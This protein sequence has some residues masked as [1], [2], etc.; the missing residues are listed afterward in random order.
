M[1]VPVLRGSLRPSVVHA[2][3]RA[4]H[5]AG[6]GQPKVDVAV[7]CCGRPNRSM[8][9]YH[10]TQ[11]LRG[12]V[13]SARLSDI[14]E[15][16]FLNAGRDAP[17][18]DAFRAFARDAEASHG[19]RVHASVAGVP[20]TAG[21][22][23]ALISGRCADNARLVREAAAAG[24]QHVYL[25]KPGAFNAADLE[26]VNHFCASKG[27]DVVMGYNKNISRYVENARA[28]D[29]STPGAS[30]TLIHQNAYPDTPE[31]LGECF[32]RNAEGMLKNMAIHELTLA[33][34][35]WGVSVSSI[36][37]VTVDP[38]YSRC[39]TLGNFTD[40]VA[41][42]FT[43]ETTD[44]KRVTIKAD[45]CGGTDSVAIVEANGAEIFRAVMVDDEL[46]KK[47][48]AQMNVNPD[49]EPYFFTQDADYITLKE[50]ACKHILSGSG[51]SPEGL[52]TISAAIEA[53]RLAEHL[54]PLLQRQLM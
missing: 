49:V 4:V 6:A 14:V 44:G 45:R 35:F 36:R 21:K 26:N 30:V 2:S 33:A 9:W 48:E 32:E 13:P 24:F 5:S 34:S 53:L 27:I 37:S 11:L 41:V 39:L 23:L 3:R 10:A 8:G 12:D 15:P 38:A 7:V 52:A 16:F 25:E 22:G 29:A 28:A 18:A 43:I 54:N 17:G 31:A 20:A 51:G 46:Q 50:R 19:V 47:V 40:F 42:G 1:V